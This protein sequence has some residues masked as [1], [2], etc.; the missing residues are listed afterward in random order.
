MPDWAEMH[1]N[2]LAK[3]YMKYVLSDPVNFDSSG[4]LKDELIVKYGFRCPN[5]CSGHGKCIK[6]I[7]FTIKNVIFSL[8]NNYLN[9]NEKDPGCTLGGVCE[10]VGKKLVQY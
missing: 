3:E 10:N 6:S 7:K 4:L 8:F 5:D 2:I 9:F 1:A